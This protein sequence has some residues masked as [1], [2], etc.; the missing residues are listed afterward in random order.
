[1]HSLANRTL[2]LGETLGLAPYILSFLQLSK[3]CM[4]ILNLNDHVAALVS[5]QRNASIALYDN[6]TSVNFTA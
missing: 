2:A 1:M 6:M 3:F 5:H 4:V